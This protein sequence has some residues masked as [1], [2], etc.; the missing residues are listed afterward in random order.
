[1]T[2]MCMGRSHIMQRRDCH[3]N[4]QPRNALLHTV[5]SKSYLNEV[6]A[7]FLSCGTARFFIASLS[8]SK[9]H[10]R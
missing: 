7:K 2:A 4:A 6:Y 8:A 9:G 3:V 5:T 10:K 1:M